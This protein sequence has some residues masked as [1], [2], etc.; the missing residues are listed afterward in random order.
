MAISPFKVIEG[1][2]SRYQSKARCN[3]LLVVYKP[4]YYL[5]PF[6]TNRKLLF[7]FWT[8]CVYE[9]PRGA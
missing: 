5:F 9:P 1:H 4:T 6:R 7:K 3:F 2:Q 8:L